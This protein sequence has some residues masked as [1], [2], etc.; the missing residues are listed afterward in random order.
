MHFTFETHN[1]KLYNLCKIV[2]MDYDAPLKLRRFTINQKVIHYHLTPVVVNANVRQ[3]LGE[4]EK[5]K[6]RFL[7]SDLER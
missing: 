5:D 3:F 7:L 4:R 2:V 1:D 6:L